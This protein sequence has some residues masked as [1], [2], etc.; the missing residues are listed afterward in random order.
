MTDDM[1][2][3]LFQKIS[4]GCLLLLE[5]VDC[6]GLDRQLPHLGQGDNAG[7]AGT[8]FPN[9]SPQEAAARSNANSAEAEDSIEDSS[10]D[11][12]EDEDENEEDNS[13]EAL[14]VQAYQA[15]RNA[16]KL[17]KRKEAKKVKDAARKQREE[18]KRKAKEKEEQL[19]SKV[20]LGGLLNAIDGV[21][22]PQGYVLMM[23]TNHK[24][25]LDPALC[26]AGRVDKMIE[27]GLATTG[28]AEAL[29]INLYKPV[30][31]KAEP[32]FDVE[33]IPRLAAE[34]A[35]RIP[36][37]TLTC[38]QLQKFVLLHRDE[39]EKAVAEV[40]EFVEKELKEKHE[41]EHRPESLSSN[42]S[43]VRIT[44][45]IE[46]FETVTQEQAE[47]SNVSTESAHW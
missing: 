34:F 43:G 17:R 5:D 6:I 24:E 42:S 25:S 35:A 32:P 10:D 33:T 26:R 28:Q 27:F 30:H 46:A 13:P 29:F 12:G 22:S 41:A 21:A 7:P 18:A 31:S 15:K 38:A 40:L 3:R 20:T 39:P 4:S 9:S 47:G 8:A 1:L 37:Q 16:K 36:P 45:D 11:Y 44:Q 14:L 23:T 19:R 2:V